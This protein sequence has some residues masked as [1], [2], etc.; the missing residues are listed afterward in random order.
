MARQL[1]QGARP[2]GRPQSSGPSGSFLITLYFIDF[3]Q[4]SYLKLPELFLFAF[5]VMYNK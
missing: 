3:F 4:R 1:S 2:S 5:V